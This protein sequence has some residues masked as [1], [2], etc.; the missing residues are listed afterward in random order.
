MVLSDDFDLGRLGLTA[1]QGRRLALDVRVGTFSFAGQPYVTDPGQL[2]VTLDISRMTGDGYS[3]RLRFRAR[4]AGPCMRC[5][6]QAGPDFSVDVR[7]VDQP[8]GGEEL[9]SP[10]IRNEV[11]D[12]RGWAR[13]A[14][15]LTLPAAILCRPE[16][17]GLCEVC[18]LNLNEAGREHSHPRSPDP[19]WAKL[20]ELKLG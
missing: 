3:L 4:L 5:L 19:R 6:Q 10:Y 20:S 17:A 1:G 11:L 16:C 8:G 13:D 7:E 15:A 18:G 2:P 9:D 14:L 12:L